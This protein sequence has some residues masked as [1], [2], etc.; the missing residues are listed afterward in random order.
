M[1]A[2]HAHVLN[3]NCELHTWIIN[4]PPKQ[5]KINVRTFG[6]QNK[7]NVFTEMSKSIIRIRLKYY[8]Y[9][10]SVFRMLITSN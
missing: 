4:Q 10:A 7:H 3:I 1:R 6:I 8:N 9:Y 2:A 5:K